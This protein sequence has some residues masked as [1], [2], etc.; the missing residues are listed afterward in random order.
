MKRYFLSLFA[1]LAMAGY[2]H[3]YAYTPN[4][5]TAPTPYTVTG[6]VTAYANGIQQPPCAVTLTG[7]LTTGGKLMKIN[8]WSS[9]DG[10]CAVANGLPYAV[11]PFHT[12]PNEG[13]ASFDL[14]INGV[15]CGSALI[16]VYT[17]DKGSTPGAV[18]VN[19]FHTAACNVAFQGNAVPVIGIT[20]SA[21]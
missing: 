14:S 11:T 4:S 21:K 2:A 8:H 19:G 20:G 3:G 7:N 13:S 16:T 17:I 9:A 6:T 12:A 1:A 5:P 10:V 18:L 15:E